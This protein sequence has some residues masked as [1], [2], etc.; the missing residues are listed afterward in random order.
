MKR[1]EIKKI[2][3]WAALQNHDHTIFLS[4]T[5]HRQQPEFDAFASELTRKAPCVHITALDRQCRIP[6]FFLADNIGF[7]ALPLERELPPFLDA[8]TFMT[9]PPPLPKDIR[10]RLEQIVR[11]CHLTLFIALSCPHCPNM[12]RNLI[13]LAVA[14]KNI[15]L[16]IIDGTLFPEMARKHQV[17]SVPC[18]ILEPDFR[19]I[20]HVDPKEVLTQMIERNPAQLSAE[21]FRQMLEQG[22]ADRV[23]HQMIQADALFQGFI[24]L[25]LHPE[26]SVRLGA[27]VVVENLTE[28]ASELAARLSPI[29]MKAFDDVSDISI[30]GDILYALGEVGDQATR[31]WIEKKIPVLTHPD[32]EDAAQEALSAIEDRL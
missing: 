24:D 6:S 1:S 28:N 11:P 27:M 30:Q 12:V 4:C 8:L 14:S 23:C 3:D 9:E 32:L 25:L 13:P 31:A 29:L 5:D 2:A 21:T 10:K 26:W 19:W 22:E 15:F 17:L 7:S 18:L 20:G 16:D